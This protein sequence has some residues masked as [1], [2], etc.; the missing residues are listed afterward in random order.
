MS[1]CDRTPPDD[2][3]S[4]GV[5]IAAYRGWV[6]ARDRLF[7]LGCR[8]AFASF[9]RGSVIQLPVRLGGESHVAVGSEVFVG[10]GSW[11]QVLE[12]GPVRGEPA[13]RIG[14]GTSIAGSCVLSAA[15]SITIGPEVL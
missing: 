10:A 5:A 14:D 11:I 8:G 1:A 3:V 6:R 4:R 9:G 15:E 12:R 13:I 2:R 7:A